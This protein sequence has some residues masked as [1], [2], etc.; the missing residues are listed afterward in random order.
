MA[1]NLSFIVKNEGILKVT[2]SHIHFK[3][4]SVLKKV[5]DKDVETSDK[6]PLKTAFLWSRDL[7]KL[8]VPLWY[9]QTGSDMPYG[10]LTAAAV[11]ILGVCE[12][13]SSIA[14][15]FLYWKVRCAVRLP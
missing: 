6:S 10:H 12:G 1:C 4:G 14:S 5:L 9:P 3:S 7:F 8:L 13:H 15:V 2:G 11:M